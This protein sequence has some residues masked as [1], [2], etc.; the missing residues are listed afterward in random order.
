MKACSTIWKRI[1]TLG[2]ALLMAVTLLPAVPAQ[3]AE[4]KLTLYVGEAI[5]FT[6]YATVTKVTSS[7]KKVLTA[8][9]D[10][11]YP[12]HA[13]LTAKKAGTSN[14]TIKTKKGT[15][16]YKV[17]VKKADFKVKITEVSEGNLVIAV[18]NNT[19]QIFD[20]VSVSYTLKGA[21]GAVLKED[22]KLVDSLIPGKTSYERVSYST[23][24]YTVDAAQCTG[25]VTVVSRTI[26]AKYTE[27]ASKL[28]IKDSVNMT[29]N[30]GYATLHLTMKNKGSKAVTGSIY[31]MIYDSDDELIGVR[32]YSVYVKGSSTDSDTIK[33]DTQ[34]TY[35]G[36]D[37]YKIVKT[38]YTKDY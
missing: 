3:A 24:S 1:A 37:H 22:V 16:K 12:T 38:L 30:E 19:K 7:N 6:D 27:S 26:S 28:S 15:T 11:E 32:P 4:K 31:I 23:Y 21:D 5:Y 36:Y 9:K 29:E 18:K 17:T 33:L 8:A 13:N 35:K 25:K 14:V 10:K 20:S 2:L 34:Y